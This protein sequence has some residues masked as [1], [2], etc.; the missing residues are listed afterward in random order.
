MVQ[1]YNAA[2][3]Y[4]GTVRR[5]S[6]IGADLLIFITFNFSLFLTIVNFGV[7]QLSSTTNDPVAIAT[8]FETK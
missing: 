4:H 5:A 7:K 2:S 1:H 8:K 3:V 6:F